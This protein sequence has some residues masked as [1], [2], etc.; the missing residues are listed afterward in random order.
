MKHNRMRIILAA[1]VLC[2]LAVGCGRDADKKKIKIQ[3]GTQTEKKT[4]EKK[5]PDVLIEFPKVIVVLRTQSNKLVIGGNGEKETSS[6]SVFYASD[7]FE[8][9]A[10]DLDVADSEITVLSRPERL[11]EAGAVWKRAGKEDVSGKAH[12]LEY[13]I[14][15]VRDKIE[16]KMADEFLSLIKKYEY[17]NTARQRYGHIKEISGYI[18]QQ[19]ERVKS[20]AGDMDITPNGVVLT[21]LE[22]KIDKAKF[23]FEMREM[24]KE[25][26]KVETLDLTDK[27][28]ERLRRIRTAADLA[29]DKI[30]YKPFKEGNLQSR[31][32][33]IC[34][35]EYTFRTEMYRKLYTRM[36]KECS[37]AL[38]S[39]LKRRLISAAAGSNTDEADAMA[40][41]MEDYF[42]KYPFMLEYAETAESVRDI[43]RKIFESWDVEKEMEKLRAVSM[44]MLRSEV[45]IFDGGKY[46]QDIRKHFLKR[47]KTDC[48]L[49]AGSNRQIILRDKTVYNIQLVDE[50]LY[51]RKKTPGTGYKKGNTYVMMV[52]INA[53]ASKIVL[54]KTVQ[55][56]SILKVQVPAYI[57]L[58]NAYVNK[59]ASGE[60][61][62]LPAYVN[63]VS[64]QDFKPEIALIYYV[65]FE[66]LAN[67]DTFGKELFNRLPVMMGRTEHIYLDG[68]WISPDQRLGD[69]IAY[70]GRWVNPKS[71][72]RCPKCQGTGTALQ[73]VKDKE[74]KEEKFIKT[75]CTKCNGNGFLFDPPPLTLGEVIERVAFPEMKNVLKVYSSR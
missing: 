38:I 7:K 49:D 6:C 73:M 45:N 52:R 37:R 29:S 28:K 19:I 23:M 35:N 46:E 56:K 10:G 51:L 14:T 75:R 74:T 26:K 2:I 66:A 58:N 48:M 16:G 4:Q 9:E 67:A 17:L 12:N 50:K 33:A 53:G 8:I 65:V 69:Y 30:S 11:G 61:S 42:Q 31:A 55:E 34:E 62:E 44:I 21:Q 1:T 36:K 60:I 15:D 40:D 72:Y 39:D 57:N 41:V 59:V 43:C 5:K 68:R 3:A 20:K 64:G 27:Q 24:A 63:W 71:R 25:I 70:K 13:Y 22:Q 32:Q 54:E 47:F 18:D